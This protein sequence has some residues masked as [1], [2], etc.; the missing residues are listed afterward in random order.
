[1]NGTPVIMELDTR[2][3]LSVIGQETAKEIAGTLLPS[4]LVLKINGG[5]SPKLFEDSLGKLLN[6]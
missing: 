6:F 2:A 1:M 4:E 3:T 5:N